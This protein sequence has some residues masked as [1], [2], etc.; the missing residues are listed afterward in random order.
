MT[1]KRNGYRW[2]S[3]ESLALRLFKFED[4]IKIRWQT[5]GK[6]ERGKVK[7][8]GYSATSARSGLKLVLEERW[9]CWGSREETAGP[10]ELWGT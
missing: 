9:P 1:V 5:G 6:G 2:A 8:C 10:K 3:R 7:K 4:G